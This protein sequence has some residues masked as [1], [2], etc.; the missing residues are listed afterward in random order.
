MGVTDPETTVRVIQTEY[1]VGNPHLIKVKGLNEDREVVFV[2]SLHVDDIGTHAIRVND[3]VPTDD[4]IVLV[5][6][7]VRKCDEH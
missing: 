4:G 2:E 6:V 7:D 5:D 1:T 3:Y